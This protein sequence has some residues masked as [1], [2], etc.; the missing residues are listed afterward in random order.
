MHRLFG[1]DGLKTKTF[2]AQNSGLRQAAASPDTNEKQALPVSER[3]DRCDPALHPV[4]D[5]EPK[6]CNVV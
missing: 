5:P 4:V 2:L 3:A 6:H 1:P